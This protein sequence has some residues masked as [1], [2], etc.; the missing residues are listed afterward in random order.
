MR[1]FLVVGCG[2]SGGAT[3]AY[4]MDQLRSELAG[5][6]VPAL[7]RGWQFVHIDVPSGA[8]EGPDGLA[9]VEEQGGTYIGAAPPSGLYPVLDHALSQ[10][11][12][13]T[14]HGLEGIATWAPREPSMVTTPVS[15]GAGQYRAVGRMI[16]LNRAR[17]I[18]DR[19]Q[20]SWDEL[21]RVETTSE[22][23]ALA[24]RVAG[25]GGFDPREAPIVLVVSSMA[26]G[27]GASMALDVCRLLTLV[28]GLD[29]RL[30]GVFMVSADV[31]DTLPPAARGGVR[32]NALAMLGE[33]VA[34]QT[35]AARRH[36]VE[37]LGALGLRDGEGASI[38]F[39]RV[40]PVGRFVGTQ[41]TLFGDGTPRA[42]YRGLGRGL[43]GLMMSGG[44]TRQFV[45]FDFG[46]T[47]SPPGDTSVLGW[48][49]RGAA[50]D[51]LPWGAFG[52]ASLSMGRDRYAEYAAQRLARSCVDRLLDGHLQPGST[53]SG[54]EQVASLLDSQ[55]PRICQLVQVPDVPADRRR[56]G[57][58]VL[59]WFAESALPY[60]QADQAARAVV[61]A[62]L[63]P[64]VPEAAGMQA[65]Q[66]VPALQRQLASR[67]GALNVACSRSAYE[68]AFHW[69]S[70]LL[71]R[72]SD[73]VADAVARFGL[74]YAVALVERLESHI[75]DF[76][77]PGSQ[78]LSSLGP[79]DVAALPREIEGTILGLRNV[80]AN[81]PALVGDLFAAMQAQVRTHVMASA[82]GFAERVLG[83]F[84]SDVLRPLAEA[85][86]E[87]Q[88]VLEAAR[89]EPP[90][91]LGL[92][93]LDTTH[94]VAWPGDDARVPTRFTQADNEVLLT[95]SEDFP[96]QYTADLVA[97]LDGA[98]PGVGF[99][100]ARQRVVTS[101]TTGL[102]PTTGGDR[103]PGGLLE[104]TAPWRSRVFPTDPDGD[105]VLVP[106]VA[107]FDVHVRPPELLA[108]ARAFVARPHES[109]RRF[110]DVSLRQY[111]ADDGPESRRSARVRLLVAKFRE[112]L[113]LAL[114]LTS[115]N[116][117]AVQAVHR[118]SVEYRYK[119]SAV[120]FEALPV[121]DELRAVLAADPSIDAS[122]RST[123]EEAVTADDTLKRIDVFGS[124]PNYSPLVFDSVL[125]PVADQWSQVSPNGR[126]SFWTWR[127]ARPL[128]A[129]LPMGDEE[130]RAMVA[131]WFLGQITGDIRRPDAPYVDPVEIWD[132]DRSRW[133]P[134]PHPL[135]TPP[136]AFLKS[137]DWL[138]AVLE[139]VLVAIARSHEAPV[140]SSLRPY[141]LLRAT[142]DATADGPA[143]G[144]HE[145]SAKERLALWLR[146]GESPSGGVS[147]VAEAASATEVIERA[148]AVEAWLGRIH[149]LAEKR[150]LAPA[151]G[152]RAGGDGNGSITSRGAASETPVFRDLAPDVVWA[153]STLLALVPAARERAERL[154]RLQP[155]PV[156]GAAAVDDGIDF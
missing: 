100:E 98:P 62:E 22:M 38:P 49:H 148:A 141:Q 66:W 79:V 17:E 122:S 91:D 9:N 101:V 116:A 1:R 76:V 115:A 25:L 54:N 113:A 11:L 97:A 147:R 19:L 92:A 149:D 111:V 139:S 24:D 108:R 144:I 151:R 60:A 110:C 44:A 51:P 48:G 12:A 96:G 40:F 152:G 121:W 138:P 117:D 99:V 16:T 43:A 134:F 37:L 3:L 128:D 145:I 35:A 72:T 21:F 83:S 114:P 137:Y 5:S 53:A 87:S 67:R 142:Y 88:R 30:M 29:P 26:G 75:N 126:A 10:R 4:L 7:P 135:L 55:W 133:V 105:D 78:R 56:A 68:W 130:R 118:Q 28:P 64:Y 2:G 102:W 80:I 103:A 58:H 146:D 20:R 50:W 13:G 15:V 86:A 23:S 36:D 52:F 8:E 112:A 95:P 127:R 84:V 31:F 153:T 45:S 61:D 41:R 104:Q 73:V 120:P 131:G 107:R 140:M 39:A 18:K 32:P 69:Q 106:S 136:S 132:P 85:L 70:H 119:F 65:A 46:N 74:P 57:D 154:A 125:R 124:Y 14:A 93:R 59:A 42:V 71:G 47:G 82:A 123:F 33:I 34:S 94:Y 6:G 27:A 156:D 129:S 81:G 143:S 77:M 63:V 109:F 90:T 155:A 150:Y 89:N